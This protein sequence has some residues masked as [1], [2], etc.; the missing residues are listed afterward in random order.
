MNKQEK[1]DNATPRLIYLPESYWEALYRIKEEQGVP[2]SRQIRMAMKA[3]C[4]S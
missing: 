4:E 1:K 2:V 3:V